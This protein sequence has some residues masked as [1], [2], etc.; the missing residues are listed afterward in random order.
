VKYLMLKVGTATLAEAQG[1]FYTVPRIGEHVEVTTAGQV[2]RYRVTDVTHEM[3]DG[4]S[5]E[6][7]IRVDLHPRPATT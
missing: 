1:D 3:A 4:K 7:R 2:V 5:T 6:Q